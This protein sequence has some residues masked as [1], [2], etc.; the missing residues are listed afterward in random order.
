MPSNE[1][2]YFECPECSST[3]LEEVGRALTYS[4]ISFYRGYPESDETET[5]FLDCLRIQCGNCGFEVATGLPRE[6]HNYLLT[7]GWI[8]DREPTGSISVDWEA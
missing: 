3:H 4:S 8:K 1:E 2:E 5:E 7:R 6:L